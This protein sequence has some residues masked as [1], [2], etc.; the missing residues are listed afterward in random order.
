M[1][2]K[3]VYYTG[4]TALI[5]FIGAVTMLIL[6]TVKLSHE[7]NDEKLQKELLISEKIQLK[8]SVDIFTKEVSNLKSKNKQLDQTIEDTRLL[9]EQK[10]N[11]ITRLLAE[12]K[13]LVPYKKKSAE[14]IDIKTALDLQIAELGTRINDLF[15]EKSKISDQM[16]QITEERNALLNEKLVPQ[17][18]AN[19]FRTEAQSGRNSRLTVI[20]RRTN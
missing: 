15:L 7:L 18:Y 19:H 8:K 14:L 11:E 20:A 9:I 2:R 10:Q 4:G 16:A 13:N 6:N 12:N 5:L 3:V 17:T 1:N